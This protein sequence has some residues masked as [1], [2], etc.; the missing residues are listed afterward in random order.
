MVDGPKYISFHKA[1][2]W[3]KGIGYNVQLSDSGLALLQTEK[4]AAYKI[5]EVSD[6]LSAS[7]VTDLAL[8]AGNKMYLLD[9]RAAIW[10]VDAD[11]G[12][13]EPLLSSHHGM[14]G[15]T[16]N[17]VV[18]DD[19]LVISDPYSEHKLMAV[20]ISSGQIVWERKEVLFRPLIVLAMTV[21]SRNHIHVLT[22]LEVSEDNGDLLIP[23][24]T[25]YVLIE[26]DN[27]GDIVQHHRLEDWKMDRS[28]LVTQVH[29]RFQMAVTTDN[30]VFAV[31]RLEKKL[32]QLLS[33][34]N[35][36]FAPSDVEGIPISAIC[37]DFEG[38][39]YA[40]DTKLGG[41]RDEGRFIMRIGT[42][43]QI[44]ERLTSYIGNA[45][46]L[47]MDVSKRLVIFNQ[48]DNQI[49]I[50]S[51][52]KQTRSLEETGRLQGYYFTTSIDSHISELVW[53][54]L[55]M[56]AHY[57]GDTHL[58]VRYYSSDSKHAIVDN[59]YVELDEYI[60]NPDIPLLTKLD[61]LKPLWSK[62]LLNPKDALLFQAQGQYLW[63]LFEFIGNEQGTPEVSSMRVYYPRTSYL[64]YLPS[65]YQEDA[66]SK[67]FLERYFSLFATFLE[68]MD[69]KIDQVVKYFDIDAV[70]GPY[71]K[72]LATWLGIASQDHWN[73]HQLRR[74]MKAAPTIF[75]QKG[76]RASIEKLVEIYTGE[77]PIIIE[78]FQVKHLLEKQ[79]FAAVVPLLYG[80]NPYCFNVLVKQEHAEKEKQ[81]IVLQKILDEHKPAY[82]EARLIVLQPWMYMDYH[83]YLG[84]NT[85]L[86]EPKL[87]M[88]DDKSSL[89][90]HTI[91]IDVER[92]N[93]M[94]I[95]TRLELDSE[96]E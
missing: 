36:P 57:E 65:V 62:P 48:K 9:E 72:W 94:D 16:S 27:Y 33:S 12:L 34:T 7:M 83:S 46:K 15:S 52:N 17:L 13:I 4:Y 58:S 5:F 28:T 95:H 67:D 41:G 73:E 80:D 71:L 86:S 30:R 24:G 1:S 20:T 69:E 10:S 78:P 51:E 90:H 60:Q 59:E 54:K 74:L 2:D 19:V 75:K 29:N 31:D 37:S 82:T 50:L 84:V 6:L 92:D 96:L 35:A 87:F 26:L 11:S 77:P 40:G 88:L 89:P 43:G 14:F 79:E 93:R 56:Q 45:D 44:R 70:S 21:D 55:S 63:L 68:G 3:D 22:P 66:K 81:R 25:P 8:G 23:E 42:D 18:S 38:H 53:H 61:G 85:Y 76:T 64:S 39:L 91:I 32:Y 49:T 47:L